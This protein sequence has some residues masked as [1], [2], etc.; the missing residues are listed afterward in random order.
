MIDLSCLDNKLVWLMFEEVAPQGELPVFS[1][2]GEQLYSHDFENVNELKI[3]AT[4][5]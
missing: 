5:L 2:A 4:D 1:L 3:N